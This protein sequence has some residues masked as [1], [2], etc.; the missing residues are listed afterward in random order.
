LQLLPAAWRWALAD[1]A[2]LQA[3]AADQPVK[4]G[5]RGE[6][7]HGW[8]VRADRV[9]L[10]IP[11]MW[12]VGMTQAVAAWRRH[13]SGPAQGVPFG[14]VFV[15]FGAGMEDKLFR[16]YESMVGP[17]VVRVDQTDPAS[18]GKYQR[19]AFAR[20]IGA[21]TRSTRQASKALRGLPPSL[22]PS[23]DQFRTFAAMRLGDYSFMRAWFETLNARVPRVT[24]AC[25]VAA[26]T[27]AFAAIDSG[28]M[29]R[30]LQHGFVRHSLVFPGFAHVDALTIDEGKHFR[31]R[32]PDAIVA[33][34]EYPHIALEGLS[35][36]ILVASVYEETAELQKVQSFL[37][38]AQLQSW[39]VAVRPHPRE[40]RKFWT[41]Q[42]DRGLFQL[43]EEDRTFHDA[44]KR[45][46]PRIVVSWYST[47]LA[48]ALN[49]GIIPV[50]VSDGDT[51]AV[52]DMV[53]PLFKRALRWPQ[54]AS[55]IAEVMASD[56]AYRAV[57]QTLQGDA[58]SL[59]E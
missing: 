32:L 41:T 39:G 11:A 51:P 16:Q 19:V 2:L 25:F 12:I 59:H 30:H 28:L 33:Q 26:D 46:R 50:T 34:V 43:A 17:S 47:A 5:P 4:R 52:R 40:D 22:A 35:S 23:C 20:I 8:L 27:P 48:D 13:R 38:W 42:V 9:G 31:R 7:L 53:Y 3:I 58:S 18:C 44:L 6:R 29:A 54:D 24:E 36:A 37:S 55:R 1:S 57:L 15:G 10:A 21:V 45:L 56:E 14:R 49:C